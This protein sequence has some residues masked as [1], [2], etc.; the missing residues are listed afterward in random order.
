[1]GNAAAT[2]A[3]PPVQLPAF[4]QDLDNLTASAAAAREGGKKDILQRNK[5][6][7]AVEQDLLLLGAYA[8]KVANGDPAILAASG[9]VAAPPRQRRASQQ[10]SQPVV[11]SIDQGN[12]GQLLVEV[13]SIAD[14]YSYE[15]RSS[16]L[17]NGIPG[18]WA[19]VSITATR[20]PVSI[21]GLTPGTIY[22]FQVRALGKL[23]FTDWSD[24][25]TRMCI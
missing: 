10:L 22:A 15:V 21:S 17:V 13:S 7:H 9:F 4:K 3:T 25:A 20:P 5:D 8:I 12:S 18:A 24:S 23:G 11:V 16:A 6:R 19:T 2:Y 14:A 1:M